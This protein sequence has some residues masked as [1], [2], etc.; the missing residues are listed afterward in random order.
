MQKLPLE[1]IRVVELGSSLAGPFAA[2]ILSQLGAEVFKVE[3]PDG[4][5]M[6]RWG[7]AEV[8]GTSAAFETFNRGKRSLAVDFNDP[9]AVAG[10]RH[11][12]AAGTHAVLQNLRPGAVDRFGLGAERLRADNPALVY[13]NLGAFG[14][15][16]P[17]H[18]LPGYD[19]LMQA[20]SG[21]IATTGEPDRDPVRVGVSLID[22]ST[23]MWGAI[24]ILALLVRRMATGSGGV[25]DGSLFESSLT[26]LSM[27]FGTL[28]VEGALP[29]RGGLHGPL[30]S[31]NGG[32]HTQDG[33][34]MV[35]VGTDAQFA[36]MCSALGLD[37]L[38]DD[39]RFATNNDR[40]TNKV[41]LRVAMETQ[42]ASATRAHW[43]ARL[44]DANVP[45]A[46]LQDLKEAAAHAQTAAMGMVQTRPD[47]AFSVLGFPLRVDGTR[48]PYEHSAPS[49]GEHNSALA[50]G[51]A[52]AK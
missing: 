16:G 6:R 22:M 29:E 52:P 5:A 46:P 48:P 41:A 47:G 11:F 1:G 36:R 24:G 50:S 51:G 2:L 17:L 32:F 44:H 10:L 33:I 43:V 8:G 39:P 14:E 4:D 31:P 12:I 26:W 21:I 13:C 38:A 18:D 19:P 20:F 28:Q 7:A 9:S 45:C 34:V 40:V 3:S 49:L 15:H 27:N 23:G 35:V 25:V 37:G 30:V 42:L